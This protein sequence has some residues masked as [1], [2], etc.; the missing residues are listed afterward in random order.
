MYKI[1][2]IKMIVLKWK[3]NLIEIYFRS[4]TYGNDQMVE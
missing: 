1:Y 4:M 3:N 2:K